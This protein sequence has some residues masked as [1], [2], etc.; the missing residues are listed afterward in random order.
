MVDG[1]EI[2]IGFDVCVGR[3]RYGAMTMGV[4]T[5]YIITHLIVGHCEGLQGLG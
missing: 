4:L 3:G 2:Q 1:R 5:W